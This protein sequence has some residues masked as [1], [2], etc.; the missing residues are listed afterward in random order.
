M[1]DNI[2]A[3]RCVRAFELCII[4]LGRL[5]VEEQREVIR[6]LTEQVLPIP[7]E[8]LESAVARTL[9]DLEDRLRRS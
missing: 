9:H 8:E 3:P 7:R 5:T 2:N 1:S 6:V 4:A